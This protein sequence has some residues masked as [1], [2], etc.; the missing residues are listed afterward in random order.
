MIPQGGQIPASRTPATQRQR[1][2]KTWKLDFERGRVTGMIDRLE[3]V[4]QAV[5]LILQTE[6]FHYL[7][8]S[9]NFGVELEGVIG[10]S[11]G[12]LESEIRRRIREALLQD[13]RIRDV[14]DITIS[15]NGDSAS[16]RFTVVTIFGAVTEEVAIDV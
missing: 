14:T 8:Y 12:L 9:K 10:M 3:A 4:K 13:D 5:F 6:R 7:I 2:S 11:A 15:V 1:P 16:V